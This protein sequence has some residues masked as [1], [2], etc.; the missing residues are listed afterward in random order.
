LIIVEVVATLIWRGD[1]FMIC[2]R[3]AH[4]ARGLLGEF[5]GGKGEPREA[6]EQA[7]IS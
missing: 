7:L 5:V 2:H 6:K 1:K 4:R 3:P